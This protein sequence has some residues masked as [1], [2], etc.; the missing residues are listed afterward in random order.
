MGWKMLKTIATLFLATFSSVAIA[1]TIPSDVQIA[2]VSA[3]NPSPPSPK[4]PSPN[5]PAPT[6]VPSLNTLNV[7][8]RVLSS[9]TRHNYT[10][11]KV[12]DPTDYDVVLVSDIGM[13]IVNGYVTIP[14]GYIS[15]SVS[16]EVNSKNSV[17]GA[18]M[19]AK[20]YDENGDVNGQTD[21]QTIVIDTPDNTYQTLSME[22]SVPPTA[23]R[24]AILLKADD[25][26]P[27]PPD[28]LFILDFKYD[29]SPPPPSPPSPPPP[30]PP[31]PPPPS[32]PSPPPPSPPPP[33]PPR[34]IVAVHYLVQSRVK[35]FDYTN[36]KVINPTDY[37]ASLIS[38]TGVNIVNGYVTILSG[39]ISSS[40]SFEVN[41]KNSV[42]GAK[43]FAKFY[44]ENGDVNGQTDYHTIVID[45]PDN[46]YQTLSMEFSLPPTVRQYA[47]FLKADDNNP[48]PPENLFILDF[49][50]ELSSTE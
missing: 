4:L 21:Y 30:S 1:R 42:V 22:F 45:T 33:S 37:E 24:Y 8:Y 50:Y 25:N 48:S 38:N 13:T 6:H 29:L 19:F 41:S 2:S 3:V 18:K 32:P 35:K 20:F 15:S 26:N 16:F 27:S 43:M 10:S 5:S 40:V 36:E 44:D 49:K 34:P 46:T 47:I 9:V 17:V 28:H 39:H 12:I 23:C 11:E 7:H 31:S 14:S